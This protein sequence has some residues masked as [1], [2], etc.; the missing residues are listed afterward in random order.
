MSYSSLEDEI[1]HKMYQHKIKYQEEAK[2]LIVNMNLWYD[3]MQNTE[4]LIPPEQKMEPDGFWYLYGMKIAI[5]D[6]SNL[7]AR[8]LEVV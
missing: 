4:S 3:I 2:Y 7:Q 5:L 1:K 6:G 8:H